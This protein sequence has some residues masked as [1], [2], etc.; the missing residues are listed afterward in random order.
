MPKP[1]NWNGIKYQHVLRDN[2]KGRYTFSLWGQLWCGLCDMQDQWWLSRNEGR[3]ES[4][5]GPY[6]YPQLVALI[7]LLS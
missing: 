1:E 3:P 4:N 5:R 7:R 6:T 2:V